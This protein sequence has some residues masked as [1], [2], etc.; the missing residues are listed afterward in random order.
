MTTHHLITMATPS[1]HSNGNKILDFIQLFTYRT[2]LTGWLSTPMCFQHHHNDS[3]QSTQHI[4]LLDQAT[5]DSSHT[6]WHFCLISHSTRIHSI[7]LHCHTPSL[8]CCH[9]HDLGQPTNQMH[10]T[11]HY[12]RS[13]PLTTPHS[14]NQL[15]IPKQIRHFHAGTNAGI[16]YCAY[17]LKIDEYILLKF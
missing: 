16:K 5:P 3:S 6:E 7:K 15:G 1:I 10:P 2:Q 8:S 9:H 11:R 12:H 14:C 17:T 13:N 4:F